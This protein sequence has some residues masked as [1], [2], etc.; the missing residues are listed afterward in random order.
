MAEVPDEPESAWPP[1]T[2]TSRAAA[3]CSKRCSRERSTTCARQPGRCPA[4]R[5]SAARLAAAPRIVPPQ[6]APDRGR[7]PPAHRRHRPVFGSSR[8]RVLAA[9]RPQLLAVHQA[10]QVRADLGLDQVLDLV[11]AAA[12]IRGEP[13]YVEGH[14]HLRRPHRRRKY[15]ADHRV[16]RRTRRRGRRTSRPRDRPWHPETHRGTSLTLGYPWAGPITKGRCRRP[17]RT[18]P[19]DHRQAASPTGSGWP[20]PA[21][22]CRYRGSR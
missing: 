21:A 18:G 8:D 16:R 22:R 17:R 9:G 15:P 11:L 19:W 13:A 4:H 7:A 5:G 2:E 12:T 3:S 1:S 20:R 10:H 14:P 6:Q